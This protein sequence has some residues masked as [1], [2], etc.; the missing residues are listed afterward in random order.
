MA[1]SG[2]AGRPCRDLRQVAFLSRGASLAKVGCIGAACPVS[3]G[4]TAL[5][6]LA[7]GADS[8]LFADPDLCLDT[9]WR[10]LARSLCSV[11]GLTG[12]ARLCCFASLPRDSISEKPTSDL[13]LLI[14][15]L[16]A[17]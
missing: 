8:C 16:Y 15:S 12:D 11:C 5:I 9:D 10:G 6:F 17:V 7:H 4:A 13:P 1:P 3:I 2:W 14:R